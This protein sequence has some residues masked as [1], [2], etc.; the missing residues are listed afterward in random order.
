MFELS[1]I[2]VNAVLLIMTAMTAAPGVCLADG[3]VIDKIYHPYVQPN[4]QDLEFRAIFQD[5]QT[6]KPDNLQLYKL[7]Y[8]RS[9]GERWFAEAYVVG[10]A[11]DDKSLHVEAY[12][13]EAKRQLT[14]QGEYWADWGLLFELERETN[15]DAWE[16]S[17]ALLAEKEWGKWSG[18]A[19]FYITGE[20][21]SDIGNELETRLGLQLRYRYSRSF[22]P[23]LEF[24]SG[25]D[26]RGLGPAILGGIKL[27]DGKQFQWEAGYI[28]GL[29]NKSP[30]QTLRLLVEFEF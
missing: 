25:Q 11:T 4:E 14:E 3:V 20:W 6:S 30:D 23:A 28:F 15:K 12:E 21:G 7:S 16:F 1:A 17:T 29:D 9:I 22:E 19:N 10:K 8:G 2:R 26:T 18:T 5:H 13:I 24:Y 27:P